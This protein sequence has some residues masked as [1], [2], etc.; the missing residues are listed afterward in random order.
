MSFVL[1]E[2]P[3]KKVYAHKLLFYRS[4]SCPEVGALKKVYVSKVY[5]LFLVPNS[6]LALRKAGRRPEFDS[7]PLDKLG[8]QENVC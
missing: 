1:G 4:L 5:V 3:F 2:I 7:L 8:S 6:I